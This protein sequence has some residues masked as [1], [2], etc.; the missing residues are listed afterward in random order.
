MRNLPCPFPVFSIHFFLDLVGRIWLV[1]WLIAAIMPGFKVF[2]VQRLPQ[3]P[4]AGVGGQRR[5][6]LNL[7]EAFLQ[8]RDRDVEG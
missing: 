7:V 5:I 2:G 1:F 3:C 6:A 4:E 8:R